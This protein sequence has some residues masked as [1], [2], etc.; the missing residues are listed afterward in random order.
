V[1]LAV[2]LL[3]TCC[4]ALTACERAPADGTADE[5]APQTETPL[6][7]G[8]PDDAPATTPA[9]DTADYDGPIPMPIRIGTNGPDLDS[10]ASYGEVTGLN[11]EGDNYLSVR[12]APSTQVKERDR[13]DPGQGVHVC[14]E[15]NGWLGVVYDKADEAKDCGTDSP[16]DSPRNYTGPCAQGW[17][18]GKFVTI[19][20]G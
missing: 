17:V 3:A 16:V 4:V 13:L 5:P 18:N 8:A 12:D 6:E 10:C 11:A 20:A 7:T 2:A 1:K 9:N 19:V 14:A 15:S